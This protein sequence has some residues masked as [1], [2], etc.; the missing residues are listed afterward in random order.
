MKHRHI[1]IGEE[2][3][4]QQEHMLKKQA[5][6][7][8]ETFFAKENERLLR[9]LREKAK[10]DEKRKALSAVVKAKDPVIIDHLLELGVGPESI[11]AMG[12]IPLAAVSWADGRLEDKERKAILKA[13][14]ERGV[15]PGS[16]NYTMLEVWLK[17][18]P[19]Q[20]LMEAWKKYARGVWEQ[21]T[22]PERV[23]MRESIVGRARKIAEAA[24]GFLGVQ[25]ISPQEKALLEELERVLS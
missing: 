2:M 3:A 24:G 22:E 14:S 15:E 23:L 6:D 19:N 20:Q 21:L 16:A 5:K 12:V 25:A 17:K 7:L 1:Q 9:E 8:E 10:V 4:M 13:A 18:K 11:L